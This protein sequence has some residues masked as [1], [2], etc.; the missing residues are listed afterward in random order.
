MDTVINK[1]FKLYEP[2]TSNIYPAV[3]KFPEKSIIP[4]TLGNVADSIFSKSVEKPINYYIN[5]G[6][7]NIKD[8][9]ALHEK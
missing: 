1:N 4:A 7:N 8:N 3:S 6:V 5:K 9:G 2:I